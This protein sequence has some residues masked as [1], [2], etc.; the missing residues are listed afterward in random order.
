[1]KDAMDTDDTA[2][3]PGVI[4]AGGRAR[5]LGGG[6]KPLCLLT[7]QT[8]I[9]DQVIARIAPQLGALAINANGDKARLAGFGLPVLP[10]SLADHPGPL[11]GVL[12]AMDWAAA[13]GASSVITVAGD[14]PFLPRDL[15]ARLCAAAPGGGVVLAASPDAEGALRRHPTCGLW[16]VAL[17]E[18]LRAD[19]GA[20]MRKV[21]LWADRQGAAAVAFPAQPVDPFFNIN[22]AEDLARARA[23]LAGGLQD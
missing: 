4:L 2:R 13:R 5:R 11:A 23:I 14:T 10:D 16:P 12:A 3:P 7:G 6:D 1:M 9:I 18:G 8:R 15:V 17:R 22:T 19:L 20:G 21:A